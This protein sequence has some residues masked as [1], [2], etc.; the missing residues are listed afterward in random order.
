MVRVA[1]H[2]SGSSQ[3][4]CKFC[5]I[6]H[7]RGQA[8]TSLWRLGF[9]VGMAQ[10]LQLASRSVLVLHAYCTGA[11]QLNLVSSATSSSCT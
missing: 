3:G 2:V 5:P 9:A 1:S 4:L 7:W 8:V 11:W 10:V 6:L